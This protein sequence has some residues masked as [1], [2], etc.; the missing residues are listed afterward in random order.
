MKTITF[1]LSNLEDSLL[2]HIKPMIDSVLSGEQQSVELPFAR[3]AQVFEYLGVDDPDM[4]T[5]GWEWDYYARVTVNGVKYVLSGDAYYSLTCTF[6]R[7]E[8]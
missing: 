1:N 5:N 6:R 3:P 8:K 4:N 7:E 2:T